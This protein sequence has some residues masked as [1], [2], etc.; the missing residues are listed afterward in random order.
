MSSR[1]LYRYIDFL[2]IFDALDYPFL[3]FLAIYWSSCTSVVSSSGDVSYD[4]LE[5]GIHFCGD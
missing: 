5:K 3:E 2:W 4:T 1:N